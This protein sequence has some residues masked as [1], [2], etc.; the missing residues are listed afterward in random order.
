[1]RHTL[2]AIVGVALALFAGAVGSAKAEALKVG[3][4]LW[5]GYAGVFIADAKGYFRDEGLEVELIGFPGPGDSLPPLI[6]GHLDLNLTTLHNLGLAAGTQDEAA[7]R[8]VYLIDSSHGADAVVAKKSIP[9]VA[10][11]RGKRIGVTLNEANHLFLMVA[12]QRA[13]L[14]EGDVDLVN[15]SAEDAGAAFVAGSLDAAV[16]WEPW[17]SKAMSEG[18]GHVVFSTQD[19][20]DLIVNAVV[21]PERTLEARPGDVAK[22]VRAVDRGVA[23]LASDP[24]EAKAIVAAKL[25][26]SPADVAGMLAGDRV[27]DLAA[28]RAL[29]LGE[30][31]AAEATLGAVLSFLRE[32]GLLARPLSPDSLISTRFVEASP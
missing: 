24:E 20:P 25:E 2:C 10:S 26:S 4:D 23:F 29:L 19:A 8:L 21:A 22:F 9:D 14:S 17:V 16:T 11:L 7:L 27:Y 13:G 3:H 18:G 5:I 6:A 31:P 30:E 12:L 32:R 28:N 15:V 1:M